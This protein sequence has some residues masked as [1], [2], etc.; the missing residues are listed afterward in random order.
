MRHLVSIKAENALFPKGLSPG[1]SIPSES[2]SHHIV[3]P[4]NCTRDVCALSPGG[5][6]KFRDQAQLA[7]KAVVGWLYRGPTANHHHHKAEKG[8]LI[9]RTMKECVRCM[10]AQLR[11]LGKTSRTSEHS[12]PVSSL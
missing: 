6:S 12:R 4:W 11:Q 8:T 10:T 5:N 2:P 1:L 3:G 7:P 9:S